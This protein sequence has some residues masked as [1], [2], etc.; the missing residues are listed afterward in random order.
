M[1]TSSYLAMLPVGGLYFSQMTLK[2]RDKILLL[3]DVVHFKPLC[4]GKTYYIYLWHIPVFFIENKLCK[5]LLVGLEMGCKQREDC[6][7]VS[8][9]LRHK[10]N[11]FQRCP[12]C[13]SSLFGGLF[14]LNHRHNIKSYVCSYN[15][16][17][18]NYIVIVNRQQHYTH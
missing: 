17:H 6:L 1:G 8:V 2:I 3:Q 10:S 15:C 13:Q 11:I 5:Y 4:Y 18:F 16:M 12:T 7:V 9:S 14:S